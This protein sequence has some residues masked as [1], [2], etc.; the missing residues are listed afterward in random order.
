MRRDC[1]VGIGGVAGGCAASGALTEAGAERGTDKR[2]GRRAQLWLEGS[3][4]S[5]LRGAQSA[6]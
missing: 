1:G 6:H 4:L 2:G 3:T 5:N